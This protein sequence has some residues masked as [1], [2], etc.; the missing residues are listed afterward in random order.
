MPDEYVAVARAIVSLGHMLLVA[1][2]T[3]EGETA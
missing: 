1:Q 3:G 2:G